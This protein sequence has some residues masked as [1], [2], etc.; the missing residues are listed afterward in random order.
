MKREIFEKLFVLYIPFHFIYDKKFMDDYYNAT[1]LLSDI[2]PNFSS[3]YFVTDFK[4]QKS[5]IWFKKIIATI[6]ILL[7]N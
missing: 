4:F 6:F 7:K 1:D 3:F 2:N 5:I